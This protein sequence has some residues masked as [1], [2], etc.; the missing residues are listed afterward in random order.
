MGC[1]HGK[2]TVFIALTDFH[3]NVLSI[4]PRCVFAECIVTKCIRPVKTYFPQTLENPTL[5]G[6]RP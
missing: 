3:R 1:K 2:N 6:V 4:F 5:G